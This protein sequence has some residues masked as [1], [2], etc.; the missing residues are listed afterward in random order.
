VIDGEAS[1][2][3]RAA[4][5]YFAARLMQSE[6]ADRLNIQCIKWRAARSDH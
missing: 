5:P 3:T 6:V 4:W 2:A 1:H